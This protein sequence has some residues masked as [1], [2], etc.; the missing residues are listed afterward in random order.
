[1]IDNKKLLILTLNFHA[2][3]NFAF[4]RTDICFKLRKYFDCEKK[5]V[6][7]S[8][9]KEKVIEVAVRE[10]NEK[11]DILIY[12]HYKK[13]GRAITS[14]SFEIHINYEKQK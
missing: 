14:I 7:I 10:I 5:Y 4:K 9:F 3:S 11:S 12:P 13:S 6:R 8:Q 1:M 2:I